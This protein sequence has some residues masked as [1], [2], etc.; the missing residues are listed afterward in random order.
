MHFSG[1]WSE[2]QNVLS[3]MLC[4]DLCGRSQ[5]QSCLHAAWQINATPRKKKPAINIQP[6]FL[7]FPDFLPFDIP[8]SSKYEL[9]NQ[10]FVCSDV[11]KAV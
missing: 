3:C 7:R 11:I 10:H 5:I 8:K 2:R 1:L 9:L 4:G 6:H